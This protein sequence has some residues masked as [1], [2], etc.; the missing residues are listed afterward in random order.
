MASAACAGTRGTSSRRAETSAQRRARRQRTE[1]RR[2]NWLVKLVAADG[3]H[4]MADSKLTQ[5]FRRLFAGVPEAEEAAAAPDLRDPGSPSVVPEEPQLSAVSREI[6]AMFK[7]QDE[8]FHGLAGGALV[9]GPSCSPTVALPMDTFPNE[10]VQHVDIPPL[11]GAPG[12]SGQG[13]NI[14]PMDTMPVDVQGV[15]SAP[16][17]GAP[18]TSCQGPSFPPMET[19]PNVDVQEEET[20]HIDG[21]P[22]TSGQDPSYLSSVPLDTVP[23]VNAQEEITYSA[24]GVVLASASVAPMDKAVD[25]DVGAFRLGSMDEQPLHIQGPEGYPVVCTGSQPKFEE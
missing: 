20:A 3:T 15:D 12:T 10:G 23:F 17:D 19:V 4:H 22:G 14:S 5:V 8:V 2:I 24:F 25:L 7:L 11:D 6:A 9:Q 18:G 21:A 13:P 16:V 1:L